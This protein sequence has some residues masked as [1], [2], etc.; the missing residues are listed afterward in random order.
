MEPMITMI[1]TKRKSPHRAE[2]PAAIVEDLHLA[3]PSLD[4]GVVHPPLELWTTTTKTNTMTTILLHLVVAATA[5][6]DVDHPHPGVAGVEDP[7]Q[8]AV[9]AVPATVAWSPTTRGAVAEVP[10]TFHIHPW[11]VRYS[12]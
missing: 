4:R 11:P 1:T 2:E 3:V 6:E 10:P 8:A 12:R 7:H 9:E 5:V